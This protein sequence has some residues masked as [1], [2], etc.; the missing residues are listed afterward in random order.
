VKERTP[1]I[2]VLLL[3]DMRSANIENL[4]PVAWADSGEALGALVADGLLH[5][6][7]GHITVTDA[8]R[9]YVRIAAAAFDAYL[10]ASQKRHSV[11]V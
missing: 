2:Y 3:N 10:A 11:A 5:I 1:V 9:P 4:T 8:G 6:E 7:A